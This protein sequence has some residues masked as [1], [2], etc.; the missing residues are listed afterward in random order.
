MSVKQEERKKAVNGLFD[1]IK[2]ECAKSQDGT[3][4]PGIL[5]RYSYEKGV[6]LR[7]LSEYFAVIRNARLITHK[8]IEEKGGWRWA[9][10][11]EVS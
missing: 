8:Y 4:E 5:S 6:S 9:I 10:T 1:Y 7:T 2:S 11:P 3:A